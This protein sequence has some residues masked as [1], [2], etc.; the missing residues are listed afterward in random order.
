MKI[1]V[2][3]LAE[4]L[5]NLD[6]QVDCSAIDGMFQEFF[7]NIRLSGTIQK[8]RTQFVLRCIL[9][10]SANLVC[11][12]S[13]E[14]YQ[15]VVTAPFD[16]TYIADTERFLLQQKE[17]DPEPPIYIRSDDRFIDISEEVR[18]VL[19]LALPMKRVAPQYREV[20]LSD[21]LAL[22]SIESGAANIAQ[23]KQHST[24]ADDRWSA[25]RNIKFEQSFDNTPRE[26]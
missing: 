23:D 15:E 2:Q 10:C 17:Y 21:I 26:S 19:A 3:G 1:R 12:R 13:G 9:E 14:D 11:D 6:E 5:H 7:G 8:I 18:Q 22:N 16:I 20:D 4:G 25:L 24:I